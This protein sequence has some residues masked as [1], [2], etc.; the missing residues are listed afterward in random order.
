MPVTLSE[1]N[2]SIQ[3]AIAGTFKNKSFDLVAEIGQVNI[4][5]ESNIA[6]IDLV[7]KGP[8][9][10]E[11][12]ARGSAQIWGKE[13]ETI[14]EFERITGVPFQSGIMVLIKVNVTYHVVFGLK[15]NIQ[16][17]DPQYTLG[18]LAQAKEK[19][20]LQLIEKYPDKIQRIDGK[21]TS[22]NQT[23][24]LPRVIQNIALITGAEAE[25]GYDFVHE[26][27]KNTYGYQ[28]QITPFVAIMQGEKSPESIRQQLIQIFQS[29]I[30]FDVIV[31]VR[32]GGASLDLNAFDQFILVEAMIRFP[33]PIF[34]G[35]GHT[36]NVSLADEVAHTAMK[37]PTKV[38]EVI[39]QH[40]K[41][42]E[43]TILQL[44]LQLGKKANDALS[45]HIHALKNLRY[46]IH[47]E[48]QEKLNQHQ[49]YLNEFLLKYQNT[50]QQ[51][52]RVK[53]KKII[54]L[55]LPLKIR[56]QQKIQQAQ[57]GLDPLLQQLN[58]RADKYLALQHQ[59][60][61]DRARFIEHQHPKRWMSKG[62]AL[63]KQN[64]KIVTHAKDIL[65]D[66]P[67]EVQMQDGTVH[68]QM[69]KTTINGK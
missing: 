4:K 66:S 48:T 31:I 56:A 50:A 24:I 54:H 15:I 28:F 37:S 39:V 47:I 69:I 1:L 26:L 51:L 49:H 57:I 14:K 45:S 23:H 6:Y 16:H 17:I 20:I 27:S 11:F 10:N 18:A 32:G 21:I 61:L 2:L 40:Q 9:G 19:T 7:E 3:S 35:I 60:I 46:D 38:A 36:R 62:F 22:Y 68:T 64:G 52:L 55:S 44:F 58:K 12:I 25:G 67:I 29:Q 30:K 8:K 33:I 43:D 41:R 13:F 65:S 53:E 63:V 59:Q 34:T 42:F 5:K